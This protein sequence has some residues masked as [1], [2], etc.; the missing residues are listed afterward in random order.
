VVPIDYLTALWGEGSRYL[1]RVLVLVLEDVQDVVCGVLITTQES[2][3][4]TA[5]QNCPTFHVTVSRQLG[6]DDVM[7]TAQL[8]GIVLTVHDD[9]DEPTQQKS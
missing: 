7:A 1:P 6:G 5:F 4:L 9:G 3:A 2:G 8:G